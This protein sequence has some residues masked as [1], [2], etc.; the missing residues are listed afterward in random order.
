MHH[1]DVGVQLARILFERVA[2]RPPVDHEVGFGAVDDL[3]VRSDMLHLGVL[4]RF[5]PLLLGDPVL[6]VFDEHR[7]H[8]LMGIDSATGH[9]HHHQP[10]VAELVI[11]A[12]V[13]LL[14]RRGELIERLFHVVDFALDHGAGARSGTPPD[15]IHPAPLSGLA[16]QDADL[17]TAQFDGSHDLSGMEHPSSLRLNNHNDSVINISAK[18]Q[19]CQSLSGFPV[20]FSGFLPPSSFRETPPDNASYRCF[21]LYYPCFVLLD[22]VVL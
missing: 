12:A 2:H 7:P 18:V 14:Q 20:E 11:G 13:R 17:R 1:M 22:Y 4:M 16:D 19:F 8:A 6:F 3:P 10:A 15:D 5:E 9:H 21:M